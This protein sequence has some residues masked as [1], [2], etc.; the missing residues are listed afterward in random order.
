MVVRHRNDGRYAVITMDSHGNYAILCEVCRKR[1][2][3]AQPAKST[4]RRAAED[5]G[6]IVVD[7]RDLCPWCGSEALLAEYWVETGR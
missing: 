2:S 1:R 5:S 6:W 7:G 3:T 4:A